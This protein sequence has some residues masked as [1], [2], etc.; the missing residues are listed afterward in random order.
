MAAL[1]VAM[2]SMY[3]FLRRHKY[4]CLFYPRRYRALRA[5]E[6]ASFAEVIRAASQH[7]EHVHPDPE[8]RNVLRRCDVAIRRLGGVE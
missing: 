4:R 8:L 2:G 5:A 1:I 6:A 7:Y 3:A